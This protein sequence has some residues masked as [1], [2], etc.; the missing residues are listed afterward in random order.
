M[1]EK[2]DAQIVADD[3]TRESYRWDAAAEAPYLHL[4]RPNPH[5]N[6]FVSH[7]NAA[8]IHRK[9]AYIRKN[10]LG[11]VMLFELWGGWQ[12]SAAPPDPLLQ[13]VKSAVFGP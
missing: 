7:D 1:F 2:P 11:G 12:P 9:V 13:A 4:E 3:Y 5:D 8:S 6:A 10:G